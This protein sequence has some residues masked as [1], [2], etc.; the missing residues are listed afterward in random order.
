MPIFEQ[1]E[2]LNNYEVIELDDC[3]RSDFI[4]L[5]I[6]QWFCEGCDL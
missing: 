5:V 3:T 6:E 2:A 4:D 1:L